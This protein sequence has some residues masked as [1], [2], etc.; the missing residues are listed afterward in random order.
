M[1]DVLA[2]GE[3]VED[4]PLVIEQ[5]L[6][7]VATAHEQARG[8]DEQSGVVAF[9]LLQH[10]DAGR[11]GGAEEQIRRQL[12][13]GIDVVIV[14]QVLANLGFR[15]AAIEHARELDNGSRAVDRQPA[16]NV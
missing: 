14:D 3:C 13:N 16:E 11:D 12:D 1:V 5:Q 8:V 2:T 9:R 10:D 6:V 15:T 4:F 7:L